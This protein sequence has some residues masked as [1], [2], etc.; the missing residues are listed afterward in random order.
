MHFR[1]NY[2][3]DT[4]YEWDEDDENAIKNAYLQIDRSKL[5]S[6]ELSHAGRLLHRLHLERGQRLILRRRVQANIRG[7][8]VNE[9]YL[10]GYQ[11]TVQGQNRQAITAIFGDGHTELIGSWKGAPLDA[12]RLME[13]EKSSNVVGH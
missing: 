1:A 8:I 10:V 12:V 9:I 2:S 11:E 5:K 4:F 3:D 13:A 6:I 7:E